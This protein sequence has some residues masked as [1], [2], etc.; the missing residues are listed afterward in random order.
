M[1]L[2][3]LRRHL[4]QFSTGTIILLVVVL[5]CIILIP[6]FLTRN[7]VVSGDELKIYIEEFLSE[8]R[9]FVDENYSLLAFNLSNFSLY[10]QPPNEIEGI[11]SK[12]HGATVF[13]NSSNS[14]RTRIT[15]KEIWEPIEY[16]VWPGM[17]KN[18]SALKWVLVKAGDY[19]L[20]SPVIYDYGLLYL[21]PGVKMRY[22]G[23]GEGLRIS[24]DGAVT[25]L[26]TLIY[27][28][29]MILKGTNSHE[30]WSN[31]QAR[32]DALS[33]FVW[34]CRGVL[35]ETKIEEINAEYK[36]YLLLD[37]IALRMRSHRYWDTPSLFREDYKELEK[38]CPS[39][40]TLSKVLNDY[41]E[42]Q[43]N[44]PPTLM[45]QIFDFLFPEI[46]TPVAVAI[47]VAVIYGVWRWIKRAKVKMV[48]D[49][50]NRN[51]I[52]VFRYY[53]T[54]INR[55][56][57]RIHIFNNGKTD[58]K[59]VR[60]IVEIVNAPVEFPS[61]T[62]LHWADTPFNDP[63]PIK[64]DIPKDGG[65]KILDVVFSQPSDEELHEDFGEETPIFV[66][67]D[68]EVSEYHPPPA[69]IPPEALRNIQLET[70]MMANARSSGC[71]IATNLALWSPGG[72]PQYHLRPGEYTLKVTLIGGNIRKTSMTF[73][74]TSPENWRDLTLRIERA[75]ARNC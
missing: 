64:V 17:P 7:P 32:F 31:L 42:M 14:E 2:S 65:F 26:G 46:I 28:D 57:A 55:K 1:T 19:H 12:T 33:E 6:S 67:N 44:P 60:G 68:T 49:H 23:E 18:T 40:A 35:N 61:I 53:R 8:Y 13:F 62:Y 29:R 43:E 15:I 51:H 38:V 74:L 5:S 3:T 22:T 30:D 34:D 73:I 72:F 27:E 66:S 16:Y 70:D 71:Y 56:H 47:I 10:L 58:A 24:G 36:F 54:Q 11:I 9:R 21:E 69:T 41:L 25:I 45:D 48:F 39:N 4:K 20:D 52:G 59:D 63:E 75:R 50:R 37:R